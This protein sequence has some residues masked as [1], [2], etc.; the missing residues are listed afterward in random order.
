MLRA[1]LPPV[2]SAL[3][4]WAAFFPLDLGSI[5]FFALVPWLTLVRA[6]LSRRRRYFAA[7]LGAFTFFALATNWVRVAHPMMYLSWAGLSL[8]LPIFWVVGL[9]LI[10]RFSLLHLFSLR[11]TSLDGSHAWTGSEF[12]VIELHETVSQRTPN[13]NRNKSRSSHGP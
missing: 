13:Q 5:G 10:R 6:P 9:D 2:L 7:Y 11:N 4:L 1:F 8:V 12:G 3:L